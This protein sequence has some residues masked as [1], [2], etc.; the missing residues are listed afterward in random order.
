MW[1]LPPYKTKNLWDRH[2]TRQVIETTAQS[3]DN[4]IFLKKIVCIWDSLGEKIGL[5]ED[6]NNYLF[7]HDGARAGVANVNDL[8]G[9]FGNQ[10]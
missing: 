4:H 6:I 2:Y 3:F 7:A 1:S 10:V 8:A 5:L 9:Y